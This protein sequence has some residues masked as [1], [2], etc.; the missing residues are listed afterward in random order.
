VETITARDQIAGELALAAFICKGFA[1]LGAVDIMQLQ[2]FGLEQDRQT[3]FG[4][5]GN[6]ITG[7]FSLPIDRYNLA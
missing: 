5:S 1:R 4:G 7:Q 2:P 3:A 6:Q